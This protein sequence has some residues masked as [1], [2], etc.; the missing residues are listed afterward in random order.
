MGEALGWEVL[1]ED[2]T[3]RRYDEKYGQLYTSSQVLIWLL[4]IQQDFLILIY[5]ILLIQTIE[6][7]QLLFFDTAVED[8]KSDE[9][10]ENSA[11]HAFEASGIIYLIDS[12]K[13]TK[14]H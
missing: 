4:E 11:R 2:K 8:F 5:F 7:L 12:L 14:F 6:R 13:I 9:L 3:L 10:V 1:A